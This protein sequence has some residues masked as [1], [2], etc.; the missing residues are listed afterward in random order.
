MCPTCYDTLEQFNVAK[1]EWI[2]NQ[3]RYEQ[4]IHDQQQLQQLDEAEEVEEKSLKMEYEIEEEE[5]EDSQNDFEYPVEYVEDLVEMNESD[6]M[7]E[8]ESVVESKPETPKK[9][10]VKTEKSNNDSNREK[11]KDVYQKLLKKCDECGKMIEKNRL[12]GHMNK[13]NGL[14]PYSCDVEG[15]EKTFYCKLLQRLHKTSIHTGTLVVCDVCNKSFPSQRSLYAHNSR[16]KN[17]NRYNCDCCDRKFNNSNSL[18]RHQA[19]HSGIREWKCENCSASFY[20]KFNLGKIFSSLI[21]P[22]H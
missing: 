5:E 16:H 8:S 6:Q 19:I 15:C 14:R 4:A 9:S 2:E 1:F 11:G 3:E 13:H 18:K 10:K 12:D 22:L 7:V 21:V 20:R 17:E